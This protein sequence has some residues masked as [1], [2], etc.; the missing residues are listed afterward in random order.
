MSKFE[1]AWDISK[2]YEILVRHFVA[3]ATLNI[4]TGP[5]GN[6]AQ[7]IWDNAAVE[8]YGRRVR[9]HISAREVQAFMYGHPDMVS[10]E[11]E[12]DRMQLERFYDEGDK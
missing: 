6:K 10:L 12:V 2:N 3:G 4:Y 9:R 11:V 5:W 1:K 7:E 8:Y